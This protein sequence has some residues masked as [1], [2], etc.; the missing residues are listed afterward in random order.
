MRL[1]IADDEE[2]TST[3]SEALQAHV[4]LAELYEQKSESLREQLNEDYELF[5]LSEDEIAEFDSILQAEADKEASEFMATLNANQ[6]DEA[7]EVEVVEE[8]E[9]EEEIA[10]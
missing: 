3:Y 6:A 7:E 2:A 4:T 10:A 8:E 9:E 1:L 5:D